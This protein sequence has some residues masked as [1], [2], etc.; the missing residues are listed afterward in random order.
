[1]DERVRHQPERDVTGHLALE[2]HGRL[3]LAIAGQRRQRGSSD[4]HASKA[5]DGKHGERDRGEHRPSARFADPR[6]N[7]QHH[8]E[9]EQTF[10]ND[11]RPLPDEIPVQPR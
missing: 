5:D 11:D 10:E 9:R 6:R 1:M 8:P 2:R 7:P 3:Q 4:R